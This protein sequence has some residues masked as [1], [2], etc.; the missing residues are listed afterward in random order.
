MKSFVTPFILLLAACSEAA[1]GS[2]H[3]HLQARDDAKP[4]ARRADLCSGGNGTGDCFP[5]TFAFQKCYD[6]A[7]T[8]TQARTLT[9]HQT[10]YDCYAYTK[11][12]SAITPATEADCQPATDCD[13]KVGNTTG[14]AK[15]LFFPGTDY[16]SWDLQLY[17]LQGMVKSFACFSRLPS[18]EP[19]MVE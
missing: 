12:C 9:P 7:G 8:W 2:G 13:L 4:C 19:G 18:G 1:Y 14:D 3:V 5:D 16:R 15:A 17:H 6:L 10:W 11:P